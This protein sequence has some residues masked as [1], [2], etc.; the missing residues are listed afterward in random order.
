MIHI[1]KYAHVFYYLKT[2]S[3][4]KFH[5]GLN[6]YY[7]ETF[8]NWPDVYLFESTFYKLNLIK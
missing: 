6:W 2:K 3:K 1:N 4:F 7:K 5:V 8:E